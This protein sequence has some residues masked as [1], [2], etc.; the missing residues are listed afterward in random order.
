M[1]FSIAEE[2]GSTPLPPSS[3]RFSS[4]RISAFTYLASLRILF[5]PL[6]SR[7]ALSSSSSSPGPAVPSKTFLPP[8]VQMILVYTPK[9]NRRPN[10]CSPCS[11]QHQN[12][13]IDRPLLSTTSKRLFQQILCSHTLTNALGGC[14]H[15]FKTLP[16][17][18]NNQPHTAALSRQSP[19]TVTPCYHFPPLPICCPILPR[20]RKS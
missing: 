15:Y 11:L 10:L 19:V 1:L 5:C 20:W 18:A 4:L 16:A 2:K 17:D 13:S 14:L 3:D 12:E 8:K 6:G 9:P 7:S